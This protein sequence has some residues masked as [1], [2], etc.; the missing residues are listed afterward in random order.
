MAIIHPVEQDGYKAEVLLEQEVTGRWRA[1]LRMS[2]IQE[3]ISDFCK[4]DHPVPN[5][6]QDK[7]HAIAE[8]YRYAHQLISENSN[9]S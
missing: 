8:A 5:D 3:D 6:Y 2:K 4:D 7:E 9:C 1:K